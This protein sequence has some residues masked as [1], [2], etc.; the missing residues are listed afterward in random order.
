[1][2][3]QPPE[4]TIALDSIHSMASDRAAA[5]LREAA[6]Q[7]QPPVD[8]PSDYQSIDISIAVWLDRPMLHKEMQARERIEARQS[9][10]HYLASQLPTDSKD[11]GEDWRLDEGQRKLLE[12]RLTAGFQWLHKT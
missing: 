9:F 4:V 2:A 10:V 1:P 5:R 12:D 11:A 6:L 3:S 7:E 8:L